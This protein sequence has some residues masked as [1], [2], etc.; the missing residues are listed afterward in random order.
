MERQFFINW[1][2]FIEEAKIRRKGQQLTQER[3]AAL[4]GVSTPTISRFENGEKDIQLST[5]L[6]ILNILGMSDLR[7]LQFE[8]S[9]A[10]YHVDRG[11]VVF[12]ARDEKKIIS[13]AVSEEALKDHF[14]EKNKNP[15]KIFEANRERIEHETRRKYF[16]GMLEPDGSVLVKTSDI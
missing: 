6:A 4:A 2:L 9:P 13:C 1:P 3:L 12:R 10:Y 7:Q 16:A 11:V 15:V 5:V 14:Q 8:N